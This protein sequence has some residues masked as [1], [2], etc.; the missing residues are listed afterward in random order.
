MA[1][2]DW[3]IER[4]LALRREPWTLNGPGRLVKVVNSGESRTEIEGYVT[5]GIHLLGRTAV[6]IRKALGLN[7]DHLGVGLRVYKLA[8]FP[9]L[10]EYEYDLSAK[11]P[12]GLSYYPQSEEE[13][14]YLEG[15]SRIP[16][17]KIIKGAAIPVLPDF[18]ELTL[19]DRLMYSWLLT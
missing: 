2:A 8:R 12:G 7:T 5:T 1:K 6:G 14:K 3:I 11:F 9:H 15:D 4:E 19:S 16:Q 13:A 10:D 17:W 18:Q